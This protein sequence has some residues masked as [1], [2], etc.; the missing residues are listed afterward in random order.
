MITKQWW[1]RRRRQQERLKSDRFRLAKQQAC[2]CITLFS[3][4]FLAS[5]VARLRRES[6]SV[7][8]FIMEDVNARQWFSLS[9]SELRYSSLEW[10]PEE[11]ASIKKR[12]WNGTR[13][14]KFETARTRSLRACLHGGWGTPGRWG[15]P[16]VHIISHLT[17]SHLHEGDPPHVTSRI[18]GLPPPCKQALSD[19]FAAVAVVVA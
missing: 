9:F 5:I 3:T 19:V 2:M 8:S 18:L 12:L 4:F 7:S 6:S 14:M 10:T 17:W 16:P 11:F 1:R 15:K 13:V